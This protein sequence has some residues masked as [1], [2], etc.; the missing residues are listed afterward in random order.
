MAF[1]SRCGSEQ[2]NGTAFCFG[3]GMATGQQVAS[4][5]V[6]ATGNG[7]AIQNSGNMEFDQSD[8]RRSRTT[9]FTFN[10]PKFLIIFAVVLAAI[11]ALVIVFSGGNG[12]KNI[13]GTWTTVGG[14]YIEFLAD[15]TMKTNV[16]YSDD[17]IRPNTYEVLSDG[18]LKW[19]RYDGAWLQ[20]F[21]DY[22]ELDV[23]GNN[24]TLISKDNPDEIISLTKQK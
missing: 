2:I 14:S 11:V 15:G 10:K 1:C 12:G 23:R 4:N 19:G 7:T 18:S 16:R 21:Y 17:R 6:M 9:N 3:C 5:S 20:Y 8:R 22:W 13:V 24:M